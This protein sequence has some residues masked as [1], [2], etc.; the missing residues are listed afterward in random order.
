MRVVP[1][2][3]GGGAVSSSMRVV[4]CECGWEGQ[5]VPAPAQREPAL[6]SGAMSV[7]VGVAVGEWGSGL[8]TQD[9]VLC[10]WVRVFKARPPQESVSSRFWDRQKELQLR[11]IG[12]NLTKVAKS[13]KKQGFCIQSEGH[14]NKC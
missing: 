4:P 2:E 3:C 5:W 1:C 14:R 12:V 10:G 9:Y 6:E 7:W 8:L 11:H 13:L